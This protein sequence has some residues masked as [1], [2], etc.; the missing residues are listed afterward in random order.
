MG[1]VASAEL[2]PLDLGVP[3]AAGVTVA[4]VAQEDPGGAARVDGVATYTALHHAHAHVH[5]H[6]HTHTLAVGTVTCLATFIQSFSQVRLETIKTRRHNN[7]TA[8][9]SVSCA[10]LSYLHV[11]YTLS[12]CLMYTLSTFKRFKAFIVI[13]AVKKH[14][15]LYNE[16]L[17]L[18]PTL[19]AERIYK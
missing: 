15:S 7:R 13:C 4:V 17:T 6:T 18:L 19:D 3:P 14:V 12:T 5:A 1:L 16:I 9:Q 11:I 10:W 2:D 8:G